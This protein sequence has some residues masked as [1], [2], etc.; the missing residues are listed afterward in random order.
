MRPLLA[1]TSQANSR[2]YPHIASEILTSEL[3]TIT[4]TIMSNKETLLT[5]FWDA[6]LPPIEALPAGAQPRSKFEESERER[7]RD[8]FWTQEDEDRDRQRELVRGM[9][10]RINCSLLMR[11]TH[12]FIRFIQS[13]PNIVDR[14]MA[15]IDSPAIQ[16]MLV[17]IVSAEE[18]GVTGVVSWLA[19][20]GIVPRL[21]DLLSPH[22]STN[23]H[24]IAAE[25]LKAI[26]TLCA[27]APFN[28]GGGNALG[29]QDGQKEQAA[30]MRDNRLIRELV[31]TTSLQT[32]LGYMLDDIELSDKEWKGLDGTGNHPGDPFVIH[33]LPSIASATSSL[34]HICN[35]LV[36]IVR[37]NNSDFSEP[38]LF[39][40]LRQRLM[41][42]QGQESP[43]SGESHD[44]KV[45]R[46]MEDA[47][48][49]LTAKMGIVYLGDL[50]ELI[51]D[52]FGEINRL[53]KQPRSQAR[54]ASA[55]T[56]APLT[57]E[58]FRLIEL[59]A[60]LL[61]S[62]NMS[63]MNRAVNKGPVYTSG[64]LLSGGLEGLEALGEAVEG[65]HEGDDDSDD[66]SEEEH[67]TKARELPVSAGSTDCSLTS[68]EVNSDDEAMLENVDIA[69]PAPQPS[70]AVPPPPSQADDERLRVVRDM[71]PP[72]AAGSELGSVSHAAVAATTVAPSIASD[73]MPR[74]STPSLSPGDRLKRMYIDHGVL[75]ALVD[76][77]FEYP[78]NNFMHHVVYDI[79]Q[80]ILNGRLGPGL[81]R[82]LIVDLISEAKLVE[83]VLYAQKLNDEAIKNP[84]TPRLPFMGHVIL[85][86]DELV[87]F[88][89]RCPQDLFHM[90]EPSIDQPAWEAFV[91]TSLRKTKEQDEATLAGGKPDPAA[92]AA[93]SAAVAAEEEEEETSSD[94]DEPNHKFGEPLSRTLAADGVAGRSFDETD[95]FW[96]GSGRRTL[97][98]SDDDDDD[99]A[100]WLRPSTMN[101][102]GGSDDEDFGGFHGGD[103]N[104]GWGSFSS[105]SSDYG[106][107][108]FGDDN[109]AFGD[110][111]FAPS[112]PA[113]T[114][115]TPLTP[116]DWAS[117]FDREF[118]QQPAGES[119]I[120]DD[121]EGEGEEHTRGGERE[122]HS[123]SSS[124][125]EETAE[126]TP[127][128]SGL[129]A[130]S[131]PALGV[132]LSSAAATEASIGTLSA[133]MA[134]LRA[135][136]ESD[137][138]SPIPIPA[139]AAAEAP[140]SAPEASPPPSSPITIP[141]RAPAA[142]ADAQAKDTLASSAS[143]SSSSSHSASPGRSPGRV[144]S[145]HAHA[146]A[147]SPSDKHAFPHGAS[148]GRVPSREV[149]SSPHAHPP[150]D[151]ALL[152]ATSPDEPLGPGVSSDT[153]VL[154]NG[155]LEKTINGKKVVVPQ[156]DIVRGVEEALDQEEE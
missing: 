149:H 134:N 115:P 48:Q 76:L 17:K 25:L 1:Q 79:L 42:L 27:P 140:T 20:Q 128:A 136:P 137:S 90:I 64:G 14:M 68:S 84:K 54:A 119:A 52:R 56:S 153:H 55:S 145:L 142:P 106:E 26:I 4:E 7:A 39:H 78:N 108:P 43:G 118:G 85:I 122:T 80:Q 132:P 87:K 143:P 131:P 31:T 61:H 150:F 19:D 57:L 144:S 92:V 24:S 113:D 44:A 75:T 127:S 103:D 89:S 151:A 41:I 3:W 121:E 5:P 152:D 77:F 69:P 2:R 141:S 63:T 154:S 107:N 112:V 47:L 138:S 62:S 35:I 116:H 99:D 40:M 50:I 22:R 53:L 120:A 146:Q 95:E 30:G 73:H 60:E 155:M 83:R 91:A 45:R 46:D 100:D 49:D 129:T 33:P 66:G 23:M 147:Q 29:Q 32:M 125:S 133:E 71:E 67:I 126:D 8:E 13:M 104:D 111:N 10:T 82:E 72:T 117:E 139:S 94:E 16:D 156:D 86:A 96:N 18:A 28:P 135:G 98:S 88:F 105:P 65:D 51:S 130:R 110:D 15:H 102:H 148:L 58:R 9:W 70:A 12:E 38:Q 6:V 124:D 21:L 37:R 11:R 114:R 34:S 93:A 109:F 59:Y 123:G 74:I 101:L 81:N 97:D 36:E